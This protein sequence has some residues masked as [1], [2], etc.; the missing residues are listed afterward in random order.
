MKLHIIHDFGILSLGLDQGKWKIVETLGPV[1]QYTWNE[2]K[3]F[4]PD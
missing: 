4:W 1:F 2:M 3:N